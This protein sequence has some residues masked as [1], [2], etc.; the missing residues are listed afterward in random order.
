MTDKQAWM[1]SAQ[2]VLR[3]TEETWLSAGLALARV[4]FA[5]AILLGHALPKLGEMIAGEGHFPELV[6]ELGFPAPLL[7]AWL[8]TLAQVGGTLL[9]ALG[10]VTRVGALMIL[11]TL[12]V[13]I[14]S[15]HWGD[16]FPVVEAGVAYLVMLTVFV[17]VGGGRYALDRPLLARLEA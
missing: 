7:F 14:I 4:Y 11:S 12:A 5:L 13:G 2:A 9:L 16:P 1:R 6:A 10:L 3:S 8:A 17:V 15:V